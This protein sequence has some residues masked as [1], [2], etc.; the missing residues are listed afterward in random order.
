MKK[1]PDSE[2][3]SQANSIYS[4]Y[5][6]D[7]INP[8]LSDSIKEALKNGKTNEVLKQY[9]NFIKKYPNSPTTEIIKYYLENYREEDI[10][11]L[12]LKKLD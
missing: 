9:N 10:R 6:Y 2:L 12:I 7:Y 4:D 3:K 5:Q 1:Y 8:L 11:E